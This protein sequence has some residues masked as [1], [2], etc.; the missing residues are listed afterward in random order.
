METT[1]HLT[2]MEATSITIQMVVSTQAA[3]IT[4]TIHPL[5]GIAVSIRTFDLVS[6]LYDKVGI[7]IQEQTPIAAEPTTEPPILADRFMA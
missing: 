6:Y 3:E 4:N 2:V 5:L 1:T 7:T